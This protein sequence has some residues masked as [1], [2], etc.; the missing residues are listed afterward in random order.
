MAFLDDLIPA[1]P[2]LEQGV[3]QFLPWLRR[4]QPGV[5]TP[6]MFPKTYNPPPAAP[7]PS[8]RVPAASPAT[9]PSVLPGS[10]LTAVPVGPGA[11]PASAPDVGAGTMQPVTLGPAPAAPIAPQSAADRLAAAKAPD[12]HG[13]KKVLDIVGQVADPRLEEAIPGSPG[14]FQT[15]TLPT[16][17]R[18][19]K[20]ES[21]SATEAL[22]ARKGGA[23]ID[24]NEAEAANQNAEAQARLNPE[25]KTRAIVIRDE[26][27]DPTPALENLE[28]G[29]ITDARGTE[30]PNA[31]MWE[32][33]ASAKEE[34]F[35]GLDLKDVQ[36]EIKS[37]PVAYPNGDIYSNRKKAAL[38]LMAE[39]AAA[40]RGPKDTT[41]RNEARTD[42]GYQFNAKELDEERKPLEA[43][44]Q[45]ISAGM[46][47]LNLNSAQADAFL[48]PQILT[49]SA[50]GAGSGLR[51]NEAE[52]NRVLGGRTTWEALKASAN[53]Y[54]T[55]PQHPQIPVAQRQAMA[56]ILKAAQQK[57]TVK[58]SV[59]EWADGALVN[60][61]DV[62]EQRQI[63]ATARKLLNA[64]D[65][66]K[67]V[68]RN[69]TT[70]EF[71]IAPGE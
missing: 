56:D 54:A 53:K 59:L 37:D 11:A 30:I 23:E 32:K 14:Y 7:M 64:V 16:L 18:Q 24:R 6:P 71:R 45:R 63:V 61:D 20:A 33:P 29:K 38:K 39:D 4:D 68:Q 22:N 70:G 17:E 49:L 36:A 19:A 46:T 3:E 44:M 42:R 48:A 41:P 43:T 52:I 66:G 8:P 50:G 35:L 26:N 28:T 60:T 10:P 5:G 9:T 34:K 27:G 21:D 47:N 69:K 15:R 40:K 57:G 31:Q 25:P 13:W 62:K 12:L 65:E 67:R 1:I 51:M 58:N 55:D 2:Q